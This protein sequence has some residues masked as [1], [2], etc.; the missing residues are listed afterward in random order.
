ML[1]KLLNISKSIKTHQQNANF[2]IKLQHKLDCFSKA[3]MHV[4]LL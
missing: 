4:I 2:F 3:D 1:K